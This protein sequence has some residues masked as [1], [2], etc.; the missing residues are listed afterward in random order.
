MPKLVPAVLAIAMLAQAAQAQTT[1][2][3]LKLNVID[4]DPAGLNVRSSPAGAIV[5]ALKAK[6]R[7]VEVHVVGQRGAWAQIDGAVLYTEDN[8]GG[9][10]LYQGRGWVAFSKLGFEEFDE[11][12][13][14]FVAPSEDSRTLLSFRAPDGTK[15]PK[16]DLLGCSGDY[17][18][19]RI[20]AIVGWTRDYCDN[21]FTTCV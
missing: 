1:A 12:V 2:C 21:Q 20:G 13:R 16:V 17:L 18:H 3:D 8:A 19:V 4:P 6:D 10:P 14:L 5:T 7:W 9:A 15:Q 11:H